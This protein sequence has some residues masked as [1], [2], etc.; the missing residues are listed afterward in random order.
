MSCSSSS[1]SIVSISIISSAVVTVIC[2][3]SV[4]SALCDR[5][6]QETGSKPSPK[7]SV[8]ARTNGEG[9]SHNFWPVVHHSRQT[10][11][12]CKSHRRCRRPSSCAAPLSC[13]SA[14]VCDGAV[15]VSRPLVANGGAAQSVHCIGRGVLFFR[16][17]GMSLACRGRFG[18]A[19][20]PAAPS[21]P[22]AHST[23]CVSVDLHSLC[24][25]AVNAHGATVARDPRGAV[26]P[27]AGCS[28]WFVDSSLTALPVCPS[29][30][31]SNGKG[32]GT[33]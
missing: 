4:T 1:I 17:W 13:T 23:Q 32:E 20:L 16:C 22:C 2:T 5:R 11:G 10:V 27:A 9:G 33:H 19:W 29:P 31:C 7:K 24:A 18:G 6:P 26:P 25:D 14:G 8:V 28:R 3:W 15:L 30:L 21:L 12:A